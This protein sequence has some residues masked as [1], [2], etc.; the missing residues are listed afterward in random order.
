MTHGKRYSFNLTLLKSSLLVRR[1]IVLSNKSL[2]HAINVLTLL[3]GSTRN[4][5]ASL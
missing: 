2:K 3:M 4:F 1:S 5:G